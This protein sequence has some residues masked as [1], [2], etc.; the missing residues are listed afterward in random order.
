[1]SKVVKIALFD[2]PT[3]VWHPLSREPREYPHKPYTACQKLQSL[4]AVNLRR[5]ADSVS[6]SSLKLLG[7]NNSRILKQSAQQL[8]KVI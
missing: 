2:N 1:M 5:A 6:L 8:F 4:T 3:V 7:P